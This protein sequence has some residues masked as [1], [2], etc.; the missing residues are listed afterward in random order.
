M[1]LFFAHKSPTPEP[2]DDPIPEDEPE[3]DEDPVPHPDP[4]VSPPV[5]D[6]SQPTAAISF[7]APSLAVTTSKCNQHA[8]C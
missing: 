1:N 3:P 5:S 8:R 7:L 2:D 6:T 4:V